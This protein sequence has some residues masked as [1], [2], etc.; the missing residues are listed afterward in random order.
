MKQFKG[1]TI[2][3]DVCGLFFA[4][5]PDPILLTSTF[6]LCLNL[7]CKEIDLLFFKDNLPMKCNDGGHV[8]RNTWEWISNILRFHF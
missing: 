8:L 3:E 4:V 1:I 2:S 7:T 5:I 6:E